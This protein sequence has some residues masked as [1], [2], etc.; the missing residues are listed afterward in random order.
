MIRRRVA[1]AL[2]ALPVLAGCAAGRDAQTINTDTISDAAGADVGALQ[3]R[4]VYLAAP[5][6]ALHGK[7]GDAP[8]Y[9]TVASR[10]DLP[11]LLTSVTSDDATSVTVRQP[12]LGGGEAS[13]AAS[14]SA[15]SPTL[16]GGA[17]L[18]LAVPAGSALQLGP[19]STHLVLQG[20][21]RQLRPGQSVR[22]TFS[23]AEA[24]STTLVVP[25][26]LPAGGSA[27]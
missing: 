24:G 15:G 4:N 9:L 27:E 12:D 6:T 11:D 5:E 23:F 13:P 17:S 3:V 19:D 10:S 22:V 1:V 16:A 8:L 26:A 25:V 2:L 21:K 18:P 20:L 14:P 7:G